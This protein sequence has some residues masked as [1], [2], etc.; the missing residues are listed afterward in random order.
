MRGVDVEADPMRTASSATMPPSEM[1]A[2]SVVPPPMSI[3]M[4]PDRLVDGQAGADGCGHRLLDELRVGG[5]GAA[6]CFG[7]RSPLDLGDGR[8]HADDDPRPV[9]PGDADAVQEQPDHPLGDLE[10]G[11]GTARAG[12]ARR[13]CSRASGRSSATRS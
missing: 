9:E 12:A 10:V 11:D 7:D 8:R 4:L 13:R 2:V 1:T 6:G 5:A 3:T